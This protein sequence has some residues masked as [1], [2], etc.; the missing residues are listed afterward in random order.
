MSLEPEPTIPDEPPDMGFN[1]YNLLPAAIAVIAKHAHGRALDIGTGKALGTH[2]LL[3]ARCSHVLSI[4]HEKKWTLEA[5]ARIKDPRATFITVPLVDDG[6]DW[7]DPSFLTD[8]EGN[9][10]VWDTVIVDGPTGIPSRGHVMNH[11]F[12]NHLGENWVMLVD[13]GAH[14]AM[15]KII[16]QWFQ[17]YAITHDFDSDAK[18]WIIKPAAS[19]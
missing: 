15:K 6:Q 2:A 5:R 19:A 13:D 8:N 14:T 9:P 17:K 1:E 11:L 7:Y 3:A 12:P 4:D 16:D 10:R 18:M